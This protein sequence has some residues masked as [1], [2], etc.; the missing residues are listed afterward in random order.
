MPQIAGFRGALWDTSKVDL[1]KVV[2]APLSGVKDK[3]AKGELVR[4]PSRAMYRYDQVF[5]AGYRVLTRT[6]LLAAVRLSPWSEGEIRPHEET[7]PTARDAATAMI[8]EAGAH[9]EPVFLGYRDAA[10][11][12]D[13]LIRN[14]DR[15]RPVF[16]VT[17]PDRTVHKLWRISS[18]ELIGKL[19]PQFAQ[20]KLHVLDGHARYEGMLAYATKLGADALPQY[21]S[22]KYG[23]ACLV[24]LED[25]AIAVA[26]RHRLVR[27]DG[28]RRDA[29]L[30]AA[31]KYFIVDKIAG[32]ATDLA[33]QQQALAESVAH[34]PAFVATFANDVDAWKLTLKPDISLVGEGVDVHRAI[35]RYE[36]VVFE[37]LFLRR[38][39]NTVATTTVDAAEVLSAVKGGASVGVIMRPVSLDQLLHANEEGALL[40]F[41]STAFHPPLATLMAFVIDPDEDLV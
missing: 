16:E 2:A 11:E 18:A 34:Q 5:D 26:P 38:V 14:I 13:R 4:D 28:I 19:R 10:R 37:Y 31:K 3:L 23:F 7:N 29:V 32:A 33:A 8:N 40:P 1:A 30:E 22:A 36:P 41:G 24:N 12:V 25:P 35:Q 39:L 20:K 27:N 17:T 6:T 9:T 21:S 15:D